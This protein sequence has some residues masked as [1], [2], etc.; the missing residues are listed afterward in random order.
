MF[1]APANASDPNKAKRAVR[2]RMVQV[3]SDAQCPQWVDSGRWVGMSRRVESGH[4]LTRRRAGNVDRIDGLLSGVDTIALDKVTEM[5]GTGA[6][7]IV[8]LRGSPKA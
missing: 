1:A 8:K 7:C 3:Y 2:R 4:S 5:L 6:R